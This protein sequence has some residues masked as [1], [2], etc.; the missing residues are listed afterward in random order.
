M[1][2]TSSHQIPT[3][4]MKEVGGPS[5]QYSDLE[6]IGQIPN[7]SGRL[8]DMD[9][10]YP[11]SRLH[12]SFTPTFT[13]TD[14]GF[15]DPRIDDNYHPDHYTTAST[16]QSQHHTSRQENR[17][18]EAHG[19]GDTLTVNYQEWEDF[20]SQLGLELDLPQQVSTWTAGESSG[21]NDDY[22]GKPSSLDEQFP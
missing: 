3:N 18:T 6:V 10:F 14:V 22:R 11:G 17:M 13:D 19:Y 15:Q 1:Q 7:S 9:G 21:V 8:S 12:A 4:L 5:F 2:A 16:V 20:I